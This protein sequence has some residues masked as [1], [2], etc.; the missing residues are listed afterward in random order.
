M[1][2]HEAGQAFEKAASIQ[3]SQLKEPDDMANTLTEAFKVYRKDSPTDAAR[4]HGKNGF[5]TDV[6][7]AA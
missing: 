2:D 1:T 4:V 3:Q 5:H 6:D 7:P